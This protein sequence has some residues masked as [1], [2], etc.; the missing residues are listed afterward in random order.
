MSDTDLLAA[1]RS[2]LSLPA[3]R[4]RQA[5]L[6]HAPDPRIAEKAE[7]LYV[8]RLLRAH[9][10]V[11]RST[12]Q[13]RA[14][15]IAPGVPDLIVFAPRVGCAAFLEVK[16]SSGGIQSPAQRDFQRDC[17][18]CGWRYLIGDRRTAWAWLVEIGVAAGDMP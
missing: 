13:A 18:V 10:C 5:A 2:G 7:Q 16:R 8:T 15:K 12:S 9:G 17:D 4:D 1:A 6:A 14:S 3:W 11:V